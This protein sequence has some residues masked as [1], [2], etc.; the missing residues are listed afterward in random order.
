MDRL[1]AVTFRPCTLYKKKKEAILETR[2][3]IASNISGPFRQVGCTVVL[4][5]MHN[6]LP[7]NGR[8][9]NPK[10]MNVAYVKVSSG[11]M[12]VHNTYLTHCNVNKEV[13]L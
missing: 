5:S 7:R 9:R 2:T 4:S 8:L 3:V 12:C 1:V 6:T 13:F 11:S 10:F